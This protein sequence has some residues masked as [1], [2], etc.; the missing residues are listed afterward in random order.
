[1]LLLLL[2]VPVAIFLNVI[3]VAVLGL[4]SLADEK[5]A[6]G[7]AHT[8]IGTLLLIPGLFLFLGV[9]WALKRVVKPAEAKA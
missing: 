2:T 8:F 9:V 4:L 6:A 3:R 1:V 7:E 5:L